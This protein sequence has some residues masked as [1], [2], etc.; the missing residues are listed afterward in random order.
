M[1]RGQSLLR[2]RLRREHEPRNP[3]F[4]HETASHGR[5]A[6]QPTTTLGIA[7]PE[8]GADS[9]FPT[10]TRVM[11]LSDPRW[12]SI[13]VILVGV[14]ALGDWIGDTDATKTGRS[15]QPPAVTPGA[16]PQSPSN[17]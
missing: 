2:P 16:P 6:W 5:L 17:K 15:N 1:F 11:R 8:P 14:Y 7:S 3:G 10:A 9:A 13:L 4:C 12:S